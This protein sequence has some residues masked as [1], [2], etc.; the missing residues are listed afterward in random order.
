MNYQQACQILGISPGTDFRDIKKKYR[1]LMSALHPDVHISARS[2]YHYNVQE[3]NIAY[4]L[5][6]EASLKDSGATCLSG[7]HQPGGKKKASGAA[8]YSV[9]DAPVNENA[10]RE[11]NIYY[12]EEDREGQVIGDFCIAR[13]KYF[14]QT[15]EEFPLF[16]RS[17]LQCSKELLDEADTALGRLKSPSKRTLIQA[18]LSYLLA[19]QFVHAAPLLPAFAAKT[20]QDPKGRFL[21]YFPTMLEFNG[22]ALYPGEVLSPGRLKGHRLYLTDGSGNELGYLSFLDDRL[23]YIL[24]PLFE[25][26]KACV[27]IQAADPKASDGSKHK[28]SHRSRA[29]YQ[30][31]HLWLRLKEDASPLPPENLNLKISRLLEQYKNAPS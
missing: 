6:K 10:Y 29:G 2:R 18:E 27:R 30:S 12:Y 20:E 28:I 25:Q 19:Q 16:L 31:L 5:L 3:I 8:V 17:I 1:K 14:W 24:I 13:G 21:Y 7:G 22:R 26:R 11:R 4:A 9:W 23:Y 15:E